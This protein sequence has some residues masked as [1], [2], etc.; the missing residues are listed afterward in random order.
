MPVNFTIILSHLSILL[1]VLTETVVNEHAWLKKLI[2]KQ[3]KH[4]CWELTFNK[5]EHFNMTYTSRCTVYRDG[6][7]ILLTEWYNRKTRPRSSTV[8]MS[9]ILPQVKIL[10]CFPNSYLTPRVNCV[11]ISIKEIWHY[12]FNKVELIHCDHCYNGILHYSTFTFTLVPPKQLS[13]VLLISQHTTIKTFFYSTNCTWPLL[14]SE[15]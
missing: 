7:S 3:G 13:G 10:S 15:M 14:P 5:T 2:I 12:S 9:V 11:S 4:S 8:A 6:T 1:Y